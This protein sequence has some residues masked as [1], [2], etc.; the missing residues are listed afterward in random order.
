MDKFN[1]LTMLLYAILMCCSF[2][3]TINIIFLKLNSHGKHSR[4]WFICNCSLVVFSLAAVLYVGSLFYEIHKY[5][6]E[7]I[8]N[9]IVVTL[10]DDSVYDSKFLTE[11]KESYQDKKSWETYYD[12][13]KVTVKVPEPTLEDLVITVLTHD[14]GRLFSI[15]KE[16]LNR[17]ELYDVDGV[18][19]INKY[20]D[21][22]VAEINNFYFEGGEL[23]SEHNGLEYSIRVA[24]DTSSIKDN[25]IQKYK[26]IESKYLETMEG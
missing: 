22:T 9:D 26:I 23:V 11:V 12:A 16:Y 20:E 13:V 2:I 17:T 24:V 6:E 3:F 14:V 18:L 7:P 1:T 10:Y 5:S 21:V 25:K 15:K 19:S 4:G 8:D